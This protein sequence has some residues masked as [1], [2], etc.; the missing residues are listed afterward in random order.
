MCRGLQASL[1]TPNRISCWQCLPGRRSRRSSGAF[2]PCRGADAHGAAAEAFERGDLSG[3]IAL[4]RGVESD[5]QVVAA[6]ADVEKR[7]L[8]R[9][10]ALNGFLRLRLDIAVGVLRRQAVRRQTA[11]GDFHPRVD[12]GC[13]E[14]RADFALQ[15][16]VALDQRHRQTEGGGDGGVQP[17]FA[18][19]HAVQ[20]DRIDRSAGD[21]VVEHGDGGPGHGVVADEEDAVASRAAF[22]HAQGLGRAAEQAHAAAEAVDVDVDLAPV[23][24]VDQH[25]VGAGF[26]RAFGGGAHVVQFHLAAESVFGTSVHGLMN[27]GH[28]GAAFHI[29]ADVN[30]HGAIRFLSRDF[31]S[32][33]GARRRQQRD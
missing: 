1:Q 6:V 33:R 21:G 23:R 14:L 25:F 19:L 20:F 10:Q 12:G 11:L 16:V 5:A 28:A 22:H 13:A 18:H 15:C 4:G 9:F 2:P 30:F 3:R 32:S 7:D 26:Q 27:V 24:V 8:A 17:Q 31:C 29:G